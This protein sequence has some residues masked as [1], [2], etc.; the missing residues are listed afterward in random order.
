MKKLFWT[1]RGMIPTGHHAYRSILSYQR[2]VRVL[3]QSDFQI[4]HSCSLFQAFFFLREFFSRALLSELLEQAIRMIDLDVTLYPY[5]HS[6]V[7]T[8][9]WAVGMVS[10]W[11]STE[12]SII[13]TTDT[14]LREIDQ[15]MLTSAVILDMS[16]AFDSINHET[17]ILKFKKVLCRI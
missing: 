6:S 10:G 12:T 1:K 2:R 15:K 11:H 9:Y 4:S 14:I 5:P 3:V 7:A 8:Q 16:T 13:G 17:L